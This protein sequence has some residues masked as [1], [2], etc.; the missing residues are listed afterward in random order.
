MRYWSEIV[1]AT[2]Y[3]MGINEGDDDS[4]EFKDRMP[5]LAN[6][7]LSMI[8]NDLKPCIKKLRIEAIKNNTNVIMPDDFLAFSGIP[9]M[10]LTKDEI[11]YHPEVYYNDWNDITLLEMGTYT[12]SYYARYGE[13]SDNINQGDSTVYKSFDLTKNYTREEYDKLFGLDTEGDPDEVVFNGIYSSVLDCLPTYIA[14]QLL[15]QD[16]LQKS[17]ILKNEFEVLCQR[18]ENNIMYQNESFK[19]P[20]GWY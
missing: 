3:K 12:I 9:I 18:L 14:A 1:K 6:E 17:S 15:A 2:L 7:C 4:D 10:L 13:I 5:I 19:S 20:G 16:D 11:I 8:A